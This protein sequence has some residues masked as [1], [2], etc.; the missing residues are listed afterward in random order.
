MVRV[1]SGSQIWSRFV[2]KVFLLAGTALFAGFSYVLWVWV[3]RAQVRY[4]LFM[5]CGGIVA[6]AAAWCLWQKIG[7]AHV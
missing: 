7:R 3:P 6:L 4:T 5:L 2:T 1:Q